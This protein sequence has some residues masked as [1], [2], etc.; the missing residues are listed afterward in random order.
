A[1]TV[2]DPMAKRV[3]SLNERREQLK[4]GITASTSKRR[5][6]LVQKNETTDRIRSLLSSMKVLQDSQVKQAQT[7]LLQAGI[8]RKEFAVAVIFGRLV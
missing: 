6:K 8:R 4:A 5:A 3:K 1:T 7:K 2:R